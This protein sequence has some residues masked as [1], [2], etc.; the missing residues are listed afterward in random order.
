MKEFCDEIL[1][2]GV[3]QEI[4]AAGL[5]TMGVSLA[6]GYLY[7]KAKPAVLYLQ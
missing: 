1:G 7:G 6:Q 5:R 4:Q 3:E 2:E